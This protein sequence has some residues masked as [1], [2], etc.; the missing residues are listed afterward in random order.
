LSDRKIYV[1]AGTPGVG[2]STILKEFKRVKPK[3]N[4]INFGDVMFDIA[5]EK[6][7]LNNRDEIR[8]LETEDF[9]MLQSR[10]VRKLATYESSFILNTHASV[11]TVDGYYPGLPRY[12]LE[13]LPIE[14][15]IYIHAPLSEI[16]ERRNKD[17]SRKRDVENIEDLREHDEMNRN[18]L[19]SYSMFCNSPVKF[20]VNA[21]GQ[22]HKCVDALCNLIK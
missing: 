11:K 21:D 22:L 16:I 9:R 19:A 3:F 18:Y 1:L 6:F 2:K 13:Q 8:M 17:K 10:V 12:V 4:V 5:K 15:F 14:C 20:L 7:K